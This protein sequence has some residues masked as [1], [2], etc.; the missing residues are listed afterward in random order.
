M[1]RSARLLARQIRAHPA[2]FST[3]SHARNA[4]T[5]TAPA[6]NVKNKS[7][8]SRMPTKTLIRSLVLTSLMGKEWLLRPSLAALDTICRSK[9]RVC[10]ADKNPIL[11]QLMRW[12]LYNHFAAGASAAEVARSAKELKDMGYQGII[13]G[14]AKE[15]VLA[16]PTDTAHSATIENGYSPAEYRMV[17]EW[18]QGTLQTLEMIGPG[19]FLAVK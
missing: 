11:N 1:E 2:H 4:V 8:M 5:D 7:P 18:K 16:N 10:N 17:E 14:Y 19:D 3:S 15:V 6:G 9:N 13:L 12:A